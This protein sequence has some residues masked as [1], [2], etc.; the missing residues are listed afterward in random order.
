M[1]NINGI[2]D[3]LSPAIKTQE[4]DI[5][6]TLLNISST[7]T[8]SEADVIA[9]QAKIQQFTLIIQVISATLKEFGDALKAS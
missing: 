1:L 8:A 5:R 9:F 7:G 4:A 6:K 3:I 2:L